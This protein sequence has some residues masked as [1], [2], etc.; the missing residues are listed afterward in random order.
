MWVADSGDD[1][2][3]AYDLASGDSIGTKEFDIDTDVRG[4]IDPGGVWS[5]GVTIWIADR[6]RTGPDDQD[7]AQGRRVLAFRLA[8]K[9]RSSG[10]DIELE[11]SGNHRAWGLWSDGETMWV[12]DGDDHKVYSYNMAKSDDDRIISISLDRTPVAHFD[13]GVRS[14]MVGVSESSAEV[15][16]AASMVHPEASFHVTPSDSNPNRQGHQV[17]LDYGANSVTVQGRAESGVDENRSRYRLSINRASSGL[18]EW[19]ADSDISGI[20]HRFGGTVS[21]ITGYGDTTWIA[22]TDGDTLFAIDADGNH[23]P[24]KDIPL[25][26]DNAKPLD[27]WTNGTTMWV[28]NNLSTDIFAYDVSSGAR[29]EDKEISVSG[30]L[31]SLTQ[32]S[33]WSDGEII[34]ISDTNNDKAYAFLLADGNRQ[35]DRDITFVDENLTSS[36]IWSDGGTL[37]VADGDRGRLFAY[38]LSDGEPIPS[39]RGINISHI[40]SRDVGGAVDIWGRDKTLYIADNTN[41]HV[42]AYNIPAPAPTGLSAS[43]DDARSSVTVQTW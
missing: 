24:S 42:F 15:T 33:M 17:S 6:Q 10:R 2:L 40:K 29:Q 43:V 13:R 19:K 12:G 18:F 30:T 9:D 39:L 8:E 4:G 11:S 38:R 21:G 1:R 3:Y 26:A 41:N 7:R 16:I 37:W 35:Q 25:H 23:D 20:G 32:S 28:F 22:I 31:H 14:Y 27:L 36:A 5:D 34:W